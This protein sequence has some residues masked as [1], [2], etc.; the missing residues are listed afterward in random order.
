[1]QR[2]LVE[3][4]V[5]SH[6]RVMNRRSIVRHLYENEDVTKQTLSER[7]G[8]SLPTVTIILEQ[9]K[10][11]GLLI[12]NV[13]EVSSGGRKPVL[14]RLNYNMHI[15][16]A[17]YIQK[18]SY[19]IM[20]ANMKKERIGL[21]S[22]SRSFADNN[23][24]WQTVFLQLREIA[25]DNHIK[26]ENL[27]GA[28]VL[29]SGYADHENAAAYLEDGTKAEAFSPWDFEEEPSFFISVDSGVCAEA[30]A[31]VI[32]HGLDCAAFLK[33]DEKITGAMI[34]ER[35][36]IRGKNN[37]IA[38]FGHMSIRPGLMSGGTQK[39]GSFAAHCS[40]RLL[41]EACSGTIEDFFSIEQK[42]PLLRGIFEHYLTYL[43][44]GI[45]NI[46]LCSDTP[47]ILGGE[48]A[49]FIPPEDFEYL[50]TLVNLS[51][52]YQPK[53]PMLFRSVQMEN[54]TLEGGLQIVID[55]F[56]D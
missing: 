17:I 52:N 16:A 15:P 50:R 24:Y 45:S 55:H 40:T 11:E 51:L 41:K 54:S 31:Q 33:V 37:R 7:L 43:A 19:S 30:H 12:E 13:S 1:M 49:D 35:K 46:I 22:F 20:V 28:V 44:A 14:Y 36:I 5:N 2:P 39:D 21:R 8:L 27:M 47:V 6:I 10:H 48:L 9:L 38:Q 3:S 53:T 23:D 18:D 29:F 26:K 4:P 42:E 34:A 56:F 32:K 25:N